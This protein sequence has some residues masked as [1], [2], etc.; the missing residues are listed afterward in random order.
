MNKTVVAVAI[1][2]GIIALVL[3]LAILLSH[4]KTPSTVDEF[5]MVSDG[6]FM[7]A[8]RPYYFVGVNFWQGMNLGEDGLSGNRTRLVEELD[9]LQQ[10]GVTNLRVMASS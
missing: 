7:L 4:R 8:D 3:G 5:V 10:L 9:H 6:K 2:L 1:G